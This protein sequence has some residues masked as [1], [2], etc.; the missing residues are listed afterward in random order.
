[1]RRRTCVA[2]VVVPQPWLAPPALRWGG[3]TQVLGDSGG[4]SG[5][6]RPLWAPGLMPGAT[7]K[8]WCL[9]QGLERRAM[10]L[11]RVGRK[12]CGNAPLHQTRRFLHPANSQ[13]SFALNLS[14]FSRAKLLGTSTLHRSCSVQAE[15]KC[16]IKGAPL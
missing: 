11:A 2:R 8:G 15:P 9:V 10:F 13:L 3:S 6:S 16:C 5:D 4:V 1:M 12:M 14:S 7:A